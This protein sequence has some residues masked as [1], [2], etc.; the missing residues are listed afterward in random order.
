MKLFSGHTAPISPFRRLVA[1]LMYFSG[2]VPSVTLERPM[3]LAALQAA[4]SACH[5]HPSWSA[6]FIKAFSLVAT[7]FPEL[8]RS[9]MLFPWPRLYEHPHSVATLNVER[10]VHGEKMVLYAHVE[11]PEQRS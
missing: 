1:D 7:R 5:L 11:K 8:R 10:Q 6:I 3:N 2:K 4:R 9:Y